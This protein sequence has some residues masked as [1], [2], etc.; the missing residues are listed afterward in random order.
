MAIRTPTEDAISALVLA[1]KGELQTPALT[2]TAI[3][4]GLEQF[5][6]V[7]GPVDFKVA[8]VARG[9]ATALRRHGED[10]QKAAFD[11]CVKM[12]PPSLK[13]AP[14]PLAVVRESA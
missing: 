7:M 9:T 4:D 2:L 11:F 13:E 5:G 8:Q 12:A 3:A 14:A 6:D 1:A 10:L